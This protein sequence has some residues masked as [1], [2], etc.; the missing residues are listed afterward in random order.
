V[1]IKLSILVQLPGKG[2][3][4]ERRGLLLK[5]LSNVSL[6]KAKILMVKTTDFCAVLNRYPAYDL[7]FRITRLLAWRFLPFISGFCSADV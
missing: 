2:D 4:F 1:A 3:Q 6:T 7:D 5:Q